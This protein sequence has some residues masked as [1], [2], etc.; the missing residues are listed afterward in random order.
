MFYSNRCRVINTEEKTTQIRKYILI[1]R[2]TRTHKYSECSK[3]LRLI[4]EASLCLTPP[5]SCSRWLTS[6]SRHYWYQDKQTKNRKTV[7]L[8]RQNRLRKGKYISSNLIN[9]THKLHLMFP[10]WHKLIL[11]Y[12]CDVPAFIIRLC[13]PARPC[14]VTVTCRHL[15]Y[16]AAF[17]RTI[18]T[19]VKDV[20][21]TSF[22]CFCSAERAETSPCRSSHE[23]VVLHYSLLQTTSSKGA[24]ERRRVINWLG[25]YRDERLCVWSEES[26]G[27]EGM[28]CHEF[29][30]SCV[31]VSVVPGSCRSRLPAGR[32]R[33]WRWWCIPGRW[34]ARPRWTECGNPRRNRSV[35]TAASALCPGTNRHRT[36]WGRTERRQRT[37][38]LHEWTEHFHKDLKI[39][40][41]VG[42]SGQCL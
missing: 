39:W 36:C 16:L 42:S 34:R 6:W 28:S 3:T 33:W 2:T 23:P 26:S 9:M 41:H 19:M 35:A 30:S 18:N 8:G 14:D 22:A 24:H 15:K 10:G 31:W 21:S 4:H 11:I 1:C 12:C 40:T 20:E 29:L 37:S 38:F 5:K 17:Y 7:S 13:W 32:R 25:Y 27:A